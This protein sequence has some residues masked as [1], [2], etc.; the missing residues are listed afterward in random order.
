MPYFA[1]IFLISYF[2]VYFYLYFKIIK[3]LKKFIVLKI[4]LVILA[5]LGYV[6]LF[7]WRYMEAKGNLFLSYWIGL[8]SLFW[9]GY[10]IYLFFLS[11]FFELGHLICKVFSRLLRSSLFYK[12]QGANLSMILLVLAFILSIYSYYETLNL[13]IEYFLVKTE[14]LPSYYPR[15][16]ILHISDVHLGPIMGLDK[17]LLIKAVYEKEKPDIV[18]STGDL[19]DGNMENR[20]FLA[21]ALADI[22][23]PFGKYAIFGNHEYYRGFSQAIE[24]T[25][26]AGFQ[27][28]IDDTF[29]IENLNISL[30]GAEDNTC[31]FFNLCQSKSNHSDI[32][33]LKRADKNSFIIYLKHKPKLE[34]G[35]WKY[36]DLMLSGHT[37]GGLYYPI[38]K[39][40]LSF[41]YIADR[42][43]HKKEKALLY[44]S[45]GVGTG[46]PPMR[47]LSP[48]DVAIIELVRTP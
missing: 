47:F 37:H 1:I 26:K 8:F 24:F 35:A 15:V 19:V 5:F 33:L 25:R 20:E 21:K 4:F 31:R 48:P 9:M 44:V 14:K 22:N 29:P 42:G 10:V 39:F 30:V 34:E 23:P 36:F 18:L 3:P 40:F 17:I 41:F 32:E 12:G 6:G 45:K 38:G 43:L 16:K 11:L 7:I 2:L 13:K 27:V 46:G 28:I